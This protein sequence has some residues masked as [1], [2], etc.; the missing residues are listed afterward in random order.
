MLDYKLRECPFCG[1]QVTVVSDCE[2]A[3]CETS[4]CDICGCRKYQIVCDFTQ[5]GCGSSGGFHTTEEG[6]IAAWNR[7]ANELDQR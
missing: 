1:K 7:R 5:G 2:E 4:N 6:A 3:S